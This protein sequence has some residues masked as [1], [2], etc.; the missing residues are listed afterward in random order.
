MTSN[1]RREQAP[2]SLK[3]PL[4]SKVTQGSTSGHLD[5]LAASSQGPA[6]HAAI[7]DGGT[8]T[9]AASLEKH[10]KDKDIHQS[11]KAVVEEKP[12]PQ[13]SARSVASQIHLIS[14]DSK[15]K[16]L[17]LACEDLQDMAARIGH[18]YRREKSDKRHEAVRRACVHRAAEVQAR[19]PED[20]QSLAKTA[21]M[22]VEHE[23]LHR[24]YVNDET[25]YGDKVTDIPRT[26]FWVSEDGYAWDMEEL[27]RAI[28]SKHGIMRNPLNKHMFVPADVR[29]IVEHPLGKRLAALGVSQRELRQGVRPAT[30]DK[31]S[32]LSET[33]LKDDEETLFVPSRRGTEAFLAY[34]ATLPIK[35]Q[36]AIHKLWVPARDSHTGMEYDASVGEALEA[37]LANQACFHKVGDLLGQAARYLRR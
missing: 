31:L 14:R 28:D 23:S 4:R 36:D 35:E 19:L 26:R 3:L 20:L 18:D 13:A 17:N 2:S 32:R 24:K 12:K 7:K 10:S 6:C 9:G 8:N 29:F 5:R 22:H 37:A 11:R 15:S 33:L 1:I 30:I 34:V 27:A 21:F 16:A 25:M